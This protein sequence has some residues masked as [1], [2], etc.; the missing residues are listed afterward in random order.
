M[1]AVFGPTTFTERRLLHPL[2]IPSAH[3]LGMSDYCS[4]LRFSVCSRRSTLAMQHSLVSSNG[5][6]YVHYLYFKVHRADSIYYDSL[7]PGQKTT[8]KI[9]SLHT[10]TLLMT[11]LMPSALSVFSAAQ[12]RSVPRIFTSQPFRSLQSILG[13]LKNLF[14]TSQILSKLSKGN[15][16]AGLQPRQSCVGKIG[17]AHV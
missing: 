5:L 12:S 16:R 11:R 8:S 13:S 10:K 14:K 1:L 7:V 3:F 2:L 6:L 17:R 15:R 4:G 9:I